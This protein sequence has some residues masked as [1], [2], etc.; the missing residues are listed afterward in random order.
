MCQTPQ[1]YQK[2]GNFVDPLT[3][4]SENSLSLSC[5]F[6]LNFLKSYNSADLTQ[7]RFIFTYIIKFYIS[8]WNNHLC[9]SILNN[10]QEKKKKIML[11]NE[12]VLIDM[13]RE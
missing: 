9:L 2:L 13:F 11:D 6:Q 4:Q 3:V 5:S 12:K 7:V 8:C 1:E 10:L